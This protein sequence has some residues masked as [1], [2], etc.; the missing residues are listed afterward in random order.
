MHTVLFHE[1]A[2]LPGFH[3]DFNHVVVKNFIQL[4]SKDAQSFPDLRMRHLCYSMLY[5]DVVVYHGRPLF[6]NFDPSSSGFD[7]W[8]NFL[9][10]LTFI[11][12]Q[13]NPD[14]RQLLADRGPNAM[15]NL[16][17]AMASSE[18]PW[19][20]QFTLY[21]HHVHAGIDPAHDPRLPTKKRYDLRHQPHMYLMDRP[22]RPV[23]LI[24]RH[25][26]DIVSM[27]AD[28]HPNSY[29][30]RNG[31]TQLCLWR[32]LQA[33]I[34]YGSG[35]L[36]ERQTLHGDVAMVGFVESDLGWVFQT[37][38]QA[39]QTRPALGTAMLRHC[40]P[41]LPDNAVVFLTCPSD[42]GDQEDSR[43]EQYK[44]KFAT[45]SQTSYSEFLAPFDDGKPPFYHT[46]HKDYVL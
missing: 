30:V 27:W 33:N 43:Y 39:N 28:H 12:T 14:V 16:Y 25:L 2:D 3:W 18:R 37:F 24:N 22:Y 5:S 34:E 13:P 23:T 7:C 44:K 21:T 6:Q 26:P 17:G 41:L 46:L 1:L 42:T 29:G 45:G 36:F 40:L 10:G 32:W 35:R 8:Y 38:W 11:G 9:R 20:D 15:A 19:E 4:L 31:F